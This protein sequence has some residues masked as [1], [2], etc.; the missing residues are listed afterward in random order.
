MSD[1]TITDA[2]T[3]AFAGAPFGFNAPVTA[4]VRLDSANPG[5]AKVSVFVGRNEGARGHSGT[6]TFR[7][8][9]WAELGRIDSDGRLVVT[10]DILEPLGAARR[11]P[12]RVRVADRTGAADHPGARR[13][14][15]ARHRHPDR[16]AGRAGA[17]AQGRRSTA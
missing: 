9:E 2:I 1:P 16:R 3:D 8:D 4:A 10:F 15:P 17:R 14:A 7:T 6:L 5:H 12:C 11:H 13:A